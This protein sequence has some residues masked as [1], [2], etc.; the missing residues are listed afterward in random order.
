MK[1]KSHSSST[2]KSDITQCLDQS[3]PT[4]LTN[5]GEFTLGK[6]LGE[7][8]FGVVRIATHILTG[9]KVAVKILEKIRILEEA[10][11]IRCCYGDLVCIKL[12]YNR[13]CSRCVHTIISNKSCD[14]CMRCWN[15]FLVALYK[16]S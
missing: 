12:Y 16:Q 7:G 3:Y 1:D 5:I 9:Q 13:F 10:D 11:K 6:K 4:K 2:I 8:T 14:C 15:D